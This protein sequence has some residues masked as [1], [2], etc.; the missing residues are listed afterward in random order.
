M[1][2][3]LRD[4]EVEVRVLV[5]GAAGVLGSALAERLLGNGVKVRAM[6][7]CRI[8][9]AWRLSASKGRIDYRWKASTDITRSDLNG[10]DVIVDA[11]IG[12][13][14]RPL[15]T[16]SPEHTTISNILPSLHLLETC[17]RL[18]PKKRP[19]IIYPSSFNALYGYA[20]GT[21][22]SPEMPPN[23]SSVYGWTKASAELLYSTYHK[24][25]GVPAIICRVGSGYGPKM[26]SDELPARLIIDV[27]NKR[28][29]HLR[30]PGSQRL[31]TY[32]E[33]ILD[34]Y[35]KL[36]GGVDEYI[37][38]TVHCAGNLGNE[39][40]TNLQLA[41]MIG[42]VASTSLRIREEAYEPGEL[43][44]GKPISFKVDGGSPLWHPKYS[45][46]R[47]LKQTCDWFSENLWRYN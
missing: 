20:S 4:R 35:E 45:L 23:P 37:G 12:V 32:M 9:E 16:A 1:G 41:Q 10:V 26:R 17:R 7:V 6:D 40:V 18:P 24:A 42:Q 15:G 2:R 21:R 29:I 36:L 28:P 39:I 3:G 31:W 47:G 25:H 46:K 33:D 27:L 43:I 19:T 22:F 14:D 11:G 30:S 34:F 38:K 13:A 5:L 8:G 44:Q